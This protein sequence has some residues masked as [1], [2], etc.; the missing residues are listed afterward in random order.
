MGA[1]RGLRFLAADMDEDQAA[2]FDFLREL[3]GGR[4]QLPMRGGF[5]RRSCR[6]V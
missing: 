4:R 5:L 2:I 1:V 6:A 3:P